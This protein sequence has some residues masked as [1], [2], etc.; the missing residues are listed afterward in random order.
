MHSGDVYHYT[1]IHGLHGMIRDKALWASHVQDLNDPTERLYGWG[2]IAERFRA[3]PPT[4]GDAPVVRLMQDAIEAARTPADWFPDAFVLSASTEPDSLTQYRLYGQHAATL[5]GGHVDG[6]SG[7]ANDWSVLRSRDRLAAGPLR[8]RRG[9]PVC[10][11]DGPC[12]G[13]DHQG[14][15]A[16][17][18]ANAA[19]TDGDANAGDARASHQG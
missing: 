15:T 18:G 9:A 4:T 16:G 5:R 12:R 13:E 6:S 19:C 14:N 2:V 17:R 1:D 10:R 3:Y 8:P 7:G 11:P